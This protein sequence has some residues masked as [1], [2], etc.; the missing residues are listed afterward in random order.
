MRDT[1]QMTKYLNL[2]RSLL[3]IEVGEHDYCIECSEDGMTREKTQ[4]YTMI[5]D[6]KPESL[7]VNIRIKIRG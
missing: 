7:N 1:Y 5:N 6:A 2:I 4:K 3:K